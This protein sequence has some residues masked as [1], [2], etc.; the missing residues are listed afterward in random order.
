M[1]TR[2]KKKAAP[3]QTATEEI[4]EAASAMSET[5]NPIVTL[6]GGTKVEI[7]K[8]RTRHVGYVMEFISFA[9]KEMNVESFGNMPTDIDFNDP[10]MLLPL[11]AKSSGRVIN[12]CAELCD[13][14]VDEVNELEIDDTIVL[15]KMQFMLN[16]DF[17]LKN[18]MPLI[19]FGNP[20]SA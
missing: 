10:Q 3:E 7:Y 14:D 12:L 18:V 13:L 9:M 16:K 6:K 2:P 4:V 20:G 15:V 11:I 19:N 1:A 5:G 17:F 8:C